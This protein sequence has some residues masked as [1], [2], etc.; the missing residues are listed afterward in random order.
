[1]PK[2]ELIV[3][4][5]KENKFY[6]KMKKFFA[7]LFKRLLRIKIVN[8]QNEPTDKNYIVC[9]NHTSLWDVVAI[10][11]GLKRQVCFMA[12]KEIFKVP[13]VNWFVK[14][15]GAFP[16]DRKSGDVGAIKKTIEILKEGNCI[17]IFPQGTRCPYKNPRDTDVKDGMGMI[18][19][20]AEV[21]ILPVAIK[22]KKGKLKFFRKTEF[23]I[24]EFIPLE[25]LIFD[26][27][28]KEQY[29]KITKFAFNET[30]KLLESERTELLE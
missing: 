15:M 11:I 5:K 28:N 6:S 3:K 21:G 23:I 18:A 30:C 17:G 2:N 9:C 1:M 12:K 10:A 14:S 25:E 7:G 8:P 16:V 4:E 22:T 26:G 19:K 27:T 29:D 24:G 13:V 20:R